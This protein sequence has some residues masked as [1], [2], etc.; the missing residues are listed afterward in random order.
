LTDAQ[1]L[2]RKVN[3]T[4]TACGLSETTTYSFTDPADLQKL[5]VNTDALGLPVEL[6]NPMNAEQS[7]MRQTIIPGLLH[8]VAYNQAHGV[9]NV[10]LYET[11][12][13][14][15]AHEGRKQPKEKE[16]LAGVLAGALADPS[17]NAAPAAFDFFDGKGV[18]ESL[19]RELALPKVRFKAL[20]A[21]DAPH[22]QPGRAA[23]MLSGG[24][25]IGWVGELHPLA[26][27]AYDA[28]APVVAFELDMEALA[29]ASRP[30]RDYVDVPEFPPV[31]MDVAFVVD[32]DVTNE[33]MVQCITS[34]GGK[35]LAD[36]RLFDV[37][38]D[39]ERVGVGKKSMAYALTYRAADRTL[40]GEE[41]EKVQA[42]LIKKVC[43]ATGAEV[44]G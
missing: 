43:G 2:A 40:T 20:S 30:A 6:I 37:Y 18:L 3:R 34:A 35:L 16:K 4:M 5:R 24:T 21:E 10:Q 26:V 32:D 38:R 13:V 7:I 31:D 17:W 11:G 39:D 33:R 9:K 42:K 1:L 14:F 36:V 25:S 28:T 44:R 8:S 41:V 23:E 29:K 12:K 19:A 15:F 27:D 22:L